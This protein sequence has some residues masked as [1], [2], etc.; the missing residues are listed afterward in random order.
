MPRRGS[1]LLAEGQP[2]ARMRAD[3]FPS[4]H[5]LGFIDLHSHVLPGLDDGAQQMDDSL[6]M[7][8][9]LRE[10]GLRCLQLL[11]HLVEGVGQLLQFSRAGGFHPL[12]ERAIRKPLRAA[13]K[14]NHRFRDCVREPEAAQEGDDDRAE[15]PCRRNPSNI[16]VN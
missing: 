1:S 11:R 8:R 3:D 6:A 4:G 13:P 15:E 12:I 5:T 7:L 16:G 2:A 14:A 10:M 9:L